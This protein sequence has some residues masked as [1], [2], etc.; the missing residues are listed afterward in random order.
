MKLVDLITQASSYTELLFSDGDIDACDITSISSDSNR[1]GPGTL[2]VAMKGATATSRDGHDYIDQAINA[3]ASAIVVDSNFVATAKFNIPVIKATNSRIALS[4]LAEIFHGYK[5][6]SIKLVGITGTNGKTSTTFMLHSILKAA[7]HRPKV[8][9]TLGYGDPEAL[10]PL[11]H[12]TMDPA[13]LSALIA[14]MADKGVTH[15]LMEISSHALMQ[16]RVRALSFSAVA[17]T[18]ITQDHL[19][20]HQ[21]IDNY[22]AAKAQLF[23]TVA[24]NNTIKILPTD[25]PFDDVGK[26]TNLRF[27]QS[28][29]GHDEEITLPFYGSFHQKN[30]RL[31][32][33]IAHALD[34]N[35]TDIRH[36]LLHCPSI[37][38]RLESIDNPHG[39][40]VF[41]DFAHTPD[42][43]RELLTTLKQL[44]HY[45][46]ILV[47]GCGG[48]R[49][50]EKRPLMGAIANDLA[51]VVIVTDDNPRTE[52]AKDIRTN[53]IAGMTNRNNS[54]IEIADRKDAI[55]H[56]IKIAKKNDLVVIAGK[57]HENYQIHGTMSHPFSDQAEAR[58]VLQNL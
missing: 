1:C 46:I 20:F 53:I 38:G 57:G 41:V 30:A 2:F 22:R 27:Y 9:G 34:V 42:A 52:E 50:R 32:R 25:H 36:G 49:D 11:S 3:G 23:F 4:Y 31:A 8:I 19:D 14:R 47:F 5:S 7:G 51:N 45:R 28:E 26:L 21:T 44:P 10:T 33:A 18:N 37:P 54:V 12:T 16:E 6:R 55:A 43:I 56:A 15:V 58:K 13:F 29:H 35:P 17:L 48:D 24:H 40:K 39:F